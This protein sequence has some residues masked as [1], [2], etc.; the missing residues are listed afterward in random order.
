MI[1]DEF[2]KTVSSYTATPGEKDILWKEIETR[3]AEKSRHYHTLTHIESLM[4]ELIPVKGSFTSWPVVVFATVYHDIIY[5]A[6]KSNNEEKSA[7]FAEERLRCIAVPP[8]LIDRCRDFIIATK[9]HE[10][11]DS[12]IDLFTDADLSILGSDSTTYQSYTRQIR[13]EYSI[14]PDVLYKPGR[15]KVL[16]HFLDMPFIYKTEF[17]RDKYE[18]KARRNLEEELDE[19]S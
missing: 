3:Y 1:K 4:L 6:S 2:L 18:D 16:L 14:Y 15:K 7:D 12:E 17:F 9:R 5:K 13:K 10:P 19:V 8:E 11:F